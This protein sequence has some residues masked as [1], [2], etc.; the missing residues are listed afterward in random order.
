MDP[1]LPPLRLL[2]VF[3]AIERHGGL[4]QA[5]AALNVSQPAVSQA[6]RQLEDFL[7]ARLLDRRT[8]P[9]RLTEA[10]RLLQQATVEGLG[11]IAEAV[12]EIGRLDAEAAR[13]L[14]IACSVGFATYWLMP[15]LATFYERHP[16][17]A[18][19]V[20]TSPQ[21]APDLGPGVDL[22]ARYGN[23]RWQDGTVTPLFAERVDPVA[24]PA[25]AGSLRQSPAPL[26]GAPLIHV[27]ASDARWT[28]WEAYLRQVGLT[29]GLTRG[30]RGSGA[31]GRDL[32]FTNYVQATQAALA[33]QGVM[34][35]WRSITGDL[36]AEGRLVPVV[37][38][39]LV[40]PDAYYLVAARRSRAAP[41]A[42][43]GDCAALIAWLVSQQ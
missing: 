6:L 20:M 15:R 14:R 3:A 39:P 28:P 38:R 41:H 24:S 1:A 33:G 9:A 23:G 31:P 2:T 25:L 12:G 34:L 40:P 35:G 30:T 37:D 22:A 27:D 11:R 43:A 42:D 19:H 21:G 4:R 7:G 10:G 29:R 13:S 32:R 16:E 18:V 17:V 8:R 5:A 26:E 36:V